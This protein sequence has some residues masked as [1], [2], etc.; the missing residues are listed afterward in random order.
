MIIRLGRLTPGYFRLLQVLHNLSPWITVYKAANCFWLF[1]DIFPQ[2]TDFHWETCQIVA[3]LPTSL[4][5][6][7]EEELAIN[8]LFI[9]GL[10]NL[11]STW[12]CMLG[13]RLHEA[14]SVHSVHRDKS[15]ARCRCVHR[16]EAL[17]PLPWRWPRW[18][19]A[20]PSIVPGRWQRSTWSTWLP[21]L[22]NVQLEWLWQ[23][24]MT[25]LFVYVAEGL[26]WRRPR[27]LI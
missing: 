15:Q 4:L 23:Q 14:W 26:W 22:R 24:M 7:V 1:H 18:E 3:V 2:I 10:C 13:K 11:L 17:I 6:L 8:K 25:F 27:G 9:H 12:W 21:E 16:A 20:C 19:W 5:Q